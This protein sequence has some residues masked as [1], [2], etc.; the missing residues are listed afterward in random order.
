M[1]EED[2]LFFYSP[3]SF[4]IKSIPGQ[5]SGNLFPG[6]DP[7]SPSEPMWEKFEAQNLERTWNTLTLRIQLSPCLS[8]GMYVPIYT[9]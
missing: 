8:V 5:A 7:L 2:L 6:P 9:H 3:F 4:F 1:M